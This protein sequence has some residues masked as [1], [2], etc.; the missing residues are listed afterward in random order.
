MINSDNLKQLMGLEEHESM[1]E[2]VGRG[3]CWMVKCTE[4]IVQHCPTPT[5]TELGIKVRF[6]GA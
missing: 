3:L 1:A 5:L 2:L 6:A 4:S